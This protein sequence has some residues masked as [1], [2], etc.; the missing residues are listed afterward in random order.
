MNILIEPNPTRDHEL[1]IAR[2]AAKILCD[3][4]ACTVMRTE[5]Y[6][7]LC[8]D[9]ENALCLDEVDIY[10]DAVVAIGGD[11]TF[12]KAAREA[13]VY[14]API[15]G[16]NLGSVGFLMELDKEELKKL[17][18][19]A[20]GE[21]SV[22][23]RMMLRAVIC[24]DGKTVYDEHALNDCIISRGG[25]M[26]SITLQLYS[27]GNH[28][29]AINGDGVVIATPTGSTAYS[30]SAGGPV[31]D[32]KTECII[33]TPICPHAL[34]AKSFVLDKEREVTIEVDSL[35]GRE[36]GLSTDGVD[37]VPLCQGDKIVIR[38]AERKI[39]KIKLNSISFFER[40]GRKLGDR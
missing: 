23:E 22:E 21:Y 2:E 34:Y 29:K 1:K 26:R 35:E 9:V 16:V 4:G 13:C 5:T 32:P 18:S 28:I 38:R 3:A 37:S 15:V 36:A 17:S 8:R 19:I 40:L 27:D 31:V 20:T 10:P 12:L 24:R 11:G 7:V 39:R 14:G 6:E 25:T 30:M 33:V